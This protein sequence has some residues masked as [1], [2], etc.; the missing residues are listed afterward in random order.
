[1]RVIAGLFR[2]RRLKGNPPAGIRPTSDKLRETLFNI[3][4]PAVEGAVFLDAYAG[5]GGVGI[6]AISRGARRVYFVD[7]LRKAC[8]II[9]EN[10]ESLDVTEGVRVI[11]SDFSRAIEMIEREGVRLDIAFLDPPYDREDLYQTSLEQLAA[12]KLLAPGGILVIEHSKRVE[13]PDAQGGLEKYRTLQQ[14]DSVLAFYRS[15]QVAS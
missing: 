8:A 6:E 7:Q 10:L 9:R 3:L 12:R 13:M 5:T 14:G 2:S 15:T 11:E 1:M 4:G